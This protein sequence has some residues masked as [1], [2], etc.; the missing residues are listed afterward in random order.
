MGYTTTGY[1]L[2]YGGGYFDRYLEKHPGVTTIGLA[3]SASE[4]SV[5]A[6]APQAHDQPLTLV[7]TPD[8]V[9]N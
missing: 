6:F 8:G 5:A 1:R 2:G 7:I 9:C 4:V 3:W